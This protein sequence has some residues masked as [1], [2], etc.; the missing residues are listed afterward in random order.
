MPA[1]AKFIPTILAFGFKFIKLQKAAEKIEANPKATNSG[2][3]TVIIALICL[4][5]ELIGVPVTP[6]L[7]EQ[8]AGIVVGIGGFYTAWKVSR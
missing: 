6:E 2:I 1:I 3:I 7:Q 8:V 4:Y 5:T